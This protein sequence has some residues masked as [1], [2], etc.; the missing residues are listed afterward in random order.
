MVHEFTA[1]LAG[2]PEL[3]DEALDR[4]WEAGC[5]DTSPGSFQGTTQITFH[6]EAETLESAIESAIAD[7]R[8]AGFDVARLETDV[9][10]VIERFNAQLQGAA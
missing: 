9:T 6:R 3:T 4:L 1:I 8:R 5:Q 2:A 10:A 7:I